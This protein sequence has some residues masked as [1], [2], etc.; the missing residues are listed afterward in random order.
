MGRPEILGGI[1]PVGCIRLRLKNCR[2]TKL[3]MIFKTQLKHILIRFLI[4][5]VVLLCSPIGYAQSERSDKLFEQG[6]TLYQAGKY[7]EAIPV[8]EE[9]DSLDKAEMEE[10]AYRRGYAEDW[11]ASCWY[12]LGNTKKAKE[13]ADQ[14]YDAAPVDRRLTV[15]HDS[16]MQIGIDLLRS[17][18]AQAFNYLIQVSKMEGELFPNWGPYRIITLFYVSIALNNQGKTDEALAVLNIAQQACET[19]FRADHPLLTDAMRMKGR[20]LFDAGRLNEAG[21]A[22]TALAEHLRNTH[23]EK[24]KVY[25]DFMCEAIQLAFA[26]GDAELLKE[27]LP[28]VLESTEEQYG[29]Q[30]EQVLNLLAS[31]ADMLSQMADSACLDVGRQYV[32]LALSMYGRESHPYLSA[33]AKMTGYAGRMARVEVMRHYLSEVRTLSSLLEPD[34]PENK[35]AFDCMLAMSYL[36]EDLDSAMVLV[37][38]NMREMEESGMMES[39]YYKMGQYVKGIA[40]GLRG[41]YAEGA[42]LMEAAIDAIPTAD[43]TSVIQNKLFLAY[44]RCM[45]GNYVG[46]RELGL[47]SIRELQ[48]R[49]DSP[50]TGGISRGALAQLDNTITIF[51][52]ARNDIVFTMPDSVQYTYGLLHRELLHLKMVQTEKL[53]SFETADFF[54]TMVQYGRTSYWTRDYMHTRQVVQA[55]T[56]KVRSRFGVYSWEYDRCLDALIA[57]YEDEEPDKRRLYEEQIDVERKIYGKKHR[58][59][60]ET[61]AEYY[62]LIGDHEAYLNIRERQVAQGRTDANGTW[63]STVLQKSDDNYETALRY[64][65]KTLDYTLKNEENLTTITSSVNGIANCLI[66]RGENDLLVKECVNLLVQVQK[67]RPAMWN[68]VAKDLILSGLIGTDIATFERCLSSIAEAFPEI[69]DDPERMACLMT[70]RFHSIYISKARLDTVARIYH[71]AMDLVKVANKRLHDELQ[72]NLMKIEYK[73]RYSYVYEPDLMVI[74]DI[75]RRGLEMQQLLSSYPDYQKT[76]DYW[77]AVGIELRAA[78]LAHDT[79]EVTRLS[80]KLLEGRKQDTEDFHERGEIVRLT[81]QGWG[82]SSRV[83]DTDDLDQM[84]TEVALMENEGSQQTELAIYAV[85]RQLETVREHLAS[86]FYTTSVS[87]DLDKLMNHAVQLAIQT[88]SDS[89]ASYAYDASIYCKGALLRS[90]KLMQRHILEQGNETSKKLLTE[91]RSTIMLQDNAALN[92]LNTDSLAKVRER[93]EQKLRQV[94]PFFGDYTTAMTASWRDIQRQLAADEAA[95][96]FC[97]YPQGDGV[98]YVALI[99]TQAMASPKVIPL[100][101]S[102]QLA[103]VHDYYAGDS[104]YQLVWEPVIPSLEHIRTV[105]FSPVGLLHMIALENVADREGRPIAEAFRLFRLSNTRELIPIERTRYATDAYLAGGV[106]YELTKDEW[107]Q[108]ATTATSAYD[109]LLAQNVTLSADQLTTRGAFNYLTGTEKEVDDIEMLLK[110]AN[111]PVTCVT[112]VDATENG[113]KAL[114]RSNKTIIHFATHGFYMAKKGTKG[115]S[116]YDDSRQEDEAMSRSGLLLAGAMSSLKG[117]VPENTDDGILTAREVSRLDLTSASLVALSACETGLGDITGDGVF[118]LQRG[119]KKAGAQSILMS[120]WKV[121][122]EAT[123]LLMTEFYKNWIGE[124]MTKHDALEAAKQTVRSYKDKGWDNP[125]YWAAFILLD[126]LD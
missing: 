85:S 24:T 55:Y 119:F 108:V 15:E 44:F 48:Q 76:S 79:D 121:D 51:N 72:L 77:A 42:H 114:E 126:A 17:E 16:L 56:D 69:G 103:A 88:A 93:L 60:L 40:L 59:L 91:L 49:L 22:W 70:D 80:K 120:L 41:E 86:P 111:I 66:K 118:G 81:G 112:G 6:V 3:P 87:D 82:Y 26:M 53:D 73:V 78:M 21:E 110:D 99:L 4:L 117:E 54:T 23:Q 109:N 90:D 27:G 61:M 1:H 71:H 100:C 123:C 89:L 37:N 115:S 104:L 95:I 113:F 10:G 105:Y 29:H 68:D 31:S 63:S 28:F 50:L 2:D 39:P 34:H 25:A 116:S 98:R 45:S 106:E 14:T 107:A 122:D 65:R 102:S 67:R 18:P 32:D 43:S 57:C 46:G 7:R 96:E 35:Y 13:I 94:S 74:D 20:Y 58:F 101:S 38:A 30:S 64:F 5:L 19:E 11:L 9:C 62:Q 125:K 97:S 83:M 84:L 8:F 12:K 47:E 33:C 52:Q 36:Q 124:R 75:R 92:H